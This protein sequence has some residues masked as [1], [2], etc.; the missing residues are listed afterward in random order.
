MLIIWLHQDPVHGFI[1]IALVQDC[2]IWHT[3]DTA[4]LHQDIDIWV[5][6]PSGIT[7]CFF[8]CPTAILGSAVTGVDWQVTLERNWMKQL[9]WYE[10]GLNTLSVGLSCLNIKFRQTFNIRHTN[11]QHFYVSHL[12]LQLSL[13][14]P[15]KPGVKLRMKMWLEQH[16]QPMLQLHLSDQQFYN[17]WMYLLYLRFE[18][19]FA[20]SIT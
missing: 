4:V 8:I 5:S 7:V 6:R 17:Q 16:Q 9:P 10:T 1:L 20:L 12:V 2:R 11:S 18:S 3:G 19:M 15:F 14:N 13:P